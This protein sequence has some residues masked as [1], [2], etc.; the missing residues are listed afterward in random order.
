MSYELWP[1]V[2]DVSSHCACAV[3]RDLCAENS[4]SIHLKPLTLDKSGF[5]Y[6]LCNLYGSMTNINRVIHQNGVQPFGKSY[7][8][9]YAC[10]KSRDVWRGVKTII[11]HLESRSLPIHYIR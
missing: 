3:S 4:F 10:A 11:I 7:I 1:L 8:D 5:V 2:T 9:V 6:S